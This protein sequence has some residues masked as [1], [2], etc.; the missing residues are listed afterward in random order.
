MM[1]RAGCMPVM[2]GCHADLLS[3][4]VQAPLQSLRRTQ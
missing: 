2:G 1:E 4:T 3:L